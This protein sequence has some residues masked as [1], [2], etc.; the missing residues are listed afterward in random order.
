MKYTKLLPATILPLLLSACFNISEGDRA[1]TIVKLS[2]RGYFCKTWEGQMVLG[3]MV[4]HTNV[5]SDGKSSTTSMV[6]NTFEFTVEDVSLI[7]KLELAL[8][9]GEQIT[10]HYKQ[11]LTTICRS[12]S[13]DYFITSVE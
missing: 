6:A 10:L 5:S 13:D 2:H 4:K 12:D 1:G 11:E 8:K 3:G 7:P 9:T